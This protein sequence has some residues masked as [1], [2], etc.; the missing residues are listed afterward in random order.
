MPFISSSV[1][2]FFYDPQDVIVSETLGALMLGE[3]ELLVRS[4][5]NN[6][7]ALRKGFW[8]PSL[9][10]KSMIFDFDVQL[11]I[12]NPWNVGCVFL[13]WFRKVSS[14]GDFFNHPP[15]LYIRSIAAPIP[16]MLDYMA[17]ARQRL[18]K[19]RNVSILRSLVTGPP[20]EMITYHW[21]H[22]KPLTWF[23]LFGRNCLHPWF[24]G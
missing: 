24:T 23:S 12:W 6:W 5:F 17:D 9:S 16:G 4:T 14:P 10:L 18:G 11:E 22:L 13:C 8:Q 19:A 21:W 20:L 7:G 1:F 3:G 2:A 15:S